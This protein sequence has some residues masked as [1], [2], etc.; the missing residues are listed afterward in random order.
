MAGTEGSVSAP[1]LALPPTSAVFGTCSSAAGYGCACFSTPAGAV[2][3]LLGLVGAILLVL[4]LLVV[5]LAAPG[6][7]HLQPAS[8]F[9]LV[10]QEQ[11]LTELVAWGLLSLLW[12]VPGPIAWCWQY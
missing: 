3:G 12:S 9:Q 11:M 7:S 4:G 2:L 10:D 1:G 8:K 6:P 5:V